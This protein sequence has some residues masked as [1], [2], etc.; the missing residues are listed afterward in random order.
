M[1]EGYKFEMGQRVLVAEADTGVR[2]A[3][4][5]VIRVA[6]AVFHLADGSVW[7]HTGFPIHKVNEGQRAS[8]L[9]PAVEAAADID[10]ALFRMAT[11]ASILANLNRDWTPLDLADVQHVERAINQA[12]I[13]HSEGI[14][15]RNMRLA[16]LAEVADL[17]DEAHIGGDPLGLAQAPYSA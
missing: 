14:L 13:R 5:E 3:L 10:R 6:D 11:A 12:I 1:A 2:V 7:T 4:S 17:I 8:P 15:D 16:F 9:L